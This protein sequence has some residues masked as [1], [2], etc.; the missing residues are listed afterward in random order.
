M[1]L[2]ERYHILV[3]GLISKGG[4]IHNDA[5]DFIVNLNIVL[6]TIKATSIEELKDFNCLP[7]H[8]L[9]FATTKS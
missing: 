4:T 9:G 2:H 5:F 3:K 6:L 7:I 8:P 1:L